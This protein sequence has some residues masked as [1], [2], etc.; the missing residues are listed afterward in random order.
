MGGGVF[1]GFPSTFPL[2]DIPAC[3]EMFG[4]PVDCRLVKLEVEISPL[5]KHEDQQAA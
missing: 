3:T 2:T 4:C 1:V 5:C